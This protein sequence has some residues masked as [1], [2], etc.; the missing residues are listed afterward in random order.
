MKEKA[1][2]LINA[3]FLESV[4]MK[5]SAVFFRKTLVRSCIDTFNFDPHHHFLNSSAI[6]IF[7]GKLD[8]VD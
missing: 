8:S 1:I 4:L 5:D 6:L 3:G 7:I 2:P